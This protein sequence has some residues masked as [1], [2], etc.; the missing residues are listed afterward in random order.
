MRDGACLYVF[1]IRWTHN[2]AQPLSQIAY[3]SDVVIEGVGDVAIAEVRSMDLIFI[4]V[5]A[6]FFAAS[7]VLIRFCANLMNKERP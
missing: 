3:R 1:F 7:V 2:F 6:V 5:F 4:G